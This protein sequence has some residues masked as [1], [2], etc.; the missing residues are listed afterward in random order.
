MMDHASVGR[1]LASALGSTELQ[2]KLHFEWKQFLQSVIGFGLIL[3]NDLERRKIEL[4]FSSTAVKLCCSLPSLFITCATP[5]TSPAAS[6]I[7]MHRRALV[8]YPVCISTSR[9]KRSSCNGKEEKKM[10]TNHFKAANC[11]APCN[12]INPRSTSQTVINCRTSFSHEENSLCS[13]SSFGSFALH[14]APS[15]TLTRRRRSGEDDICHD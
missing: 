7:G 10:F 9:L 3:E 15:P 4:T 8:L 11:I 5:M 1:R 13:Q 14:K 6:L 12:N 2:L